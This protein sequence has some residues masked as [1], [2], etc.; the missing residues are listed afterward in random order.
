MGVRGEDDG[1]ASLVEHL[2][3][4]SGGI[5]FAYGLS[6]ARGVH[7]YDDAGLGDGVGGLLQDRCD[8]PVREVA[9]DLYEVGVTEDLEPPGERGLTDVRVVCRVEFVGLVP[10]VDPLV[11]GP[12]HLLVVHPVYAADDVIVGEG[13]GVDIHALLCT[14]Y[15]VYLDPEP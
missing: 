9:E 12:V 6:E 8:I 1:D 11:R 14:W 10:V 5:D 13:R 7:V 15:V 2:E 4:V 3:E